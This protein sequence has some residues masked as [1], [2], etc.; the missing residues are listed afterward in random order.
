VN[1]VVNLQSISKRVHY[2][3]FVAESKYQQDPAEFDAAIAS[4][5]EAEL[6]SLITDAAVETHVLDRVYRK[7]ETYGREF[8]GGPD[9]YRVNPDAVREIYAR[10]IIPMNK[11]VQVRYLLAR[12]GGR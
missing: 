1:D 3:K 5:D 7:A 10:W 8:E 4:A 2:G 12:T 11:D 6:L 9:Q